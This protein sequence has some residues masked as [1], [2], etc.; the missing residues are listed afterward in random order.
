M[1]SNVQVEG[2]ITKERGAL[3]FCSPKEKQPKPGAKVQIIDVFALQVVTGYIRDPHG[4]LLL[5]AQASV[6]AGRNWS[7]AK[8]AQ[9]IRNDARPNRWVALQVD[10]YAWG[11]FWAGGGLQHCRELLAKEAT[12]SENQSALVPANPETL[13]RLILDLHADANVSEL[14]SGAIPA[15]LR[16][17]GNPLANQWKLLIYSSIAWLSILLITISAFVVAL[18]KQDR[19]LELLLERTT[20]SLKQK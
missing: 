4:R 10:K 14:D 1:A 18:E 16:A 17:A 3:L 6:A 15:P 19:K 2:C 13:L 7:I 12:A 8:A 9:L 11:L 5:Q 20:P